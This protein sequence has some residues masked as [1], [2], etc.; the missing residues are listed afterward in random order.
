MEIMV[1]DFNISYNKKTNKYELYSNDI[2]N[3]THTYKTYPVNNYGQI[4]QNIIIDISDLTK[5]GYRYNPD[6]VKTI[7]EKKK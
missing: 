5:L 2:S 7:P 6:L 1:N 3:I 4:S